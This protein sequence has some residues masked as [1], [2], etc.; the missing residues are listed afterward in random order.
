MTVA[1][2]DNR[3]FTTEEISLNFS[4]VHEHIQEE[5]YNRPFLIVDSSIV[6]NKSRRFKA[7]LPL[8]KPHFAVKSNPDPRVLQVLIEEGVGFE[9]A[10][11]AE[12]DILLSLNVSAE[13]I[14][15]SNPMKSRAY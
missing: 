11:I 4:H 7:S 5:G 9:I 15:Y 12:L 2:P 6:R 13:E 1:T 14:F 3:S 10:S 8:V